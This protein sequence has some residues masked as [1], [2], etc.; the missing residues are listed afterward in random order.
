MTPN[1]GPRMTRR[2]FLLG[3][4]GLALGAVAMGTGGIT[5]MTKIE[6]G[7]FDLNTV[8]LKLPRLDPAFSGFRLVQISDFHFRRA[9][10][11]EKITEVVQMV[12]STKPDLLALTGDY[13]QYKDNGTRTMTAL[14]DPLKQILQLAPAVAV[15]GNHDYRTG[16]AYVRKM[17]ADLNIRELSN[18]VLTLT[19]GDAQLHIA[20]VDDPWFGR[21][22]LED[23]VARLPG[24][25]AAILLAHEPDYADVVART[26]RFDLQIS[27]HTHG[28]QVVLP[29]I[30]PPVLPHMGHKYVAGLYQVGNMLQYTNRGLGMMDPYIRFNCRPEVTLFILQP[31]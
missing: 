1:S 3:L 31:A 4:G 29:L 5:Y 7:W 15:L 2:K 22:Q 13:F 30:G 20:G 9:M 8:T 12:I 23:V 24:N 11:A 14:S 28:G 27:G 6:P 25:S 16:V 19:R 18:D 17:F 10:P 26:G 21:P